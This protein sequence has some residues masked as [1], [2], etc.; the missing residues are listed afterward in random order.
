VRLRAG[1]S[2]GR[3]A[4]ARSV[5]LAALALGASAAL[6]R[7]GA[8]RRLADVATT[9]RIGPNQALNVVVVSDTEL[10]ATYAGGGDGP[11]DVVVTTAA[12]EATVAGGFL[13]VAR[14]K[15]PTITE[16]APDSGQGGTRVTIRG[17]GFEE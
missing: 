2:I 1:S 8:V 13:H 9:V 4:A 10:L 5:L 3:R 15:P 11:E 6:V 7:L 12:G 17:T 16:I 14:P